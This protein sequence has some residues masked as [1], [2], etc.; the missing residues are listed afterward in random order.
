M[1][2]W[3][4]WTG[5]E[6]SGQVPPSSL[7]CVLRLRLELEAEGLLF[8][9]GTDVLWSP[10]SNA[11]DPTWGTWSS[12]CISYCLEGRTV[13]IRRLVLFAII[14]LVLFAIIPSWC[15]AIHFLDHYFSDQIISTVLFTPGINMALLHC[16]SG[17]I[18]DGLNLKAVCVQVFLTTFALF[19][20]TIPKH[21][22]PHKAF[23]ALSTCD[24]IT[25]NARFNGIYTLK[26]IS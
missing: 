2:H 7:F 26:T 19:T 6:S 23:L 13:E 17:S 9:G 1:W 12:Y 20:D 14:R 15:S 18:Q 3:H 5:G 4:C 25:V 22:R 10:C 21:V 11:N 24:L 8:C 16:V